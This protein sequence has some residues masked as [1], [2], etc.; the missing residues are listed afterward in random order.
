MA[1][2]KIGDEVFN[3]EVEGPESAPCLL[4]SNSLG[5]TLKMWD[6][7]MP[8]LTQR[9]RVIRYDSRGHGKSA[10]PDGEG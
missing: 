4:L 5:T 6:P 8:A 1:G 3:I 2:V 10:A 9:F 7:Q